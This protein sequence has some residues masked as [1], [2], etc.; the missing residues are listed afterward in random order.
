MLDNHKSNRLLNVHHVARGLGCTE[1]TIYSLI[2]DGSL[3]AIRIG[4]RALRITESSLN[5]FL[6]SREINS[7]EYFK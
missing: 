6:E 2:Q 5:E 3:K 4:K 7:E 1:N